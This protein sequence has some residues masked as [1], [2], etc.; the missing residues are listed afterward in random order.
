[1]QVRAGEVHRLGA[2]AALF[3]VELE[4]DPPMT[5]HARAADELRPLA[6]PSGAVHRLVLSRQL[7]GVGAEP[8]AQV[9]ASEEAAENEDDADDD[10]EPLHGTILHQACEFRKFCPV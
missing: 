1:M 6:L 3:G 4:D 2:A 5:L 7:L 10:P 8:P 9:G